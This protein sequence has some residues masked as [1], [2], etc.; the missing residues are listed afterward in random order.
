MA[1]DCNFKD[2]DEMIRDRVVFSIQSEKIRE[3][4][5]NVGEELT[6]DKAIQ[7]A[8]AYE[9]SQEQLKLMG[10]QPVHVQAVS[11]SKPHV[12]SSADKSGRR[13]KTQSISSKTTRIPST[14]MKTKPCGKCGK[15]SGT[16][17]PV[18]VVRDQ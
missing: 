3:K 15:R 18:F 16:T 13:P 12:Y 11:K 9:Y 8:Q 10:Q 7:I 2:T 4:L 6:L 14:T 17:L 1:R 5:I